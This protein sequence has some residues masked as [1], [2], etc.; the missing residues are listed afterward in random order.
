MQVKF[1]LSAA[2][3]SPEDYP[4]KAGQWKT[5]KGFGSATM[6]RQPGTDRQPLKQTISIMPRLPSFSGHCSRDTEIQ[7]AAAFTGV[8]CVISVE[9]FLLLFKDMTIF[10]L[11]WENTSSL[12]RGTT[13]T[14]PAAG[15]NCLAALAIQEVQRRLCLTTLTPHPALN[16][17][18]DGKSTFNICLVKQHLNYLSIDN[19]MP[20]CIFLN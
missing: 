6:D 19:L 2:E 17:S 12:R 8:C 10:L 5:E 14:S 15:R 16:C 9:F 18:S 13:Y 20:Y 1:H 7:M 11:M 4:R 3:L